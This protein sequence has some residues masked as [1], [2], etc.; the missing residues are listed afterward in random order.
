V[1]SASGEPLLQGVPPIPAG[2][3]MGGRFFPSLFDP[4]SLKADD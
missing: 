4:R 2:Q 1:R 3:P